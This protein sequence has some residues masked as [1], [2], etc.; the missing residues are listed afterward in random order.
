MPTSGVSCDSSGGTFVCQ[1]GAYQI[2]SFF[3]NLWSKI[4]HRLL[5][6][7]LQAPLHA[8]VWMEALTVNRDVG[9]I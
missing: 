2:L 9:R 3:L 8:L 5:Y 7:P 6:I 4:A 1:Y